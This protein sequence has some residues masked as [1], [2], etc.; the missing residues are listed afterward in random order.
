M[1]SGCERNILRMLSIPYFDSKKSEYFL[2]SVVCLFSWLHISYGQNFQVQPRV[3]L[4]VMSLCVCGLWCCACNLQLK[5]RWS[6]VK[7]KVAGIIITTSK[8]EVDQSHGFSPV[9]ASQQSFNQ[10]LAEVEVMA[11]E[12]TVWE[13]LLRLGGWM[14][15]NNCWTLKYSL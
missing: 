6:A 10:L 11:M 13:S 9:R 12:K 1:Q 4:R 7:S 15:P 14:I 5:L 2:L 8:S 3:G